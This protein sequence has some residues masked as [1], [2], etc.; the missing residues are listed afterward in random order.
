LT[1]RLAGALI[2]VTVLSASAPSGAAA[3]AAI[4]AERIVVRAKG[5]RAVI[6]REPFRI[7]FLGARGRVLRQVE[8]TRA[9][10]F[11]DTT[12]EPE[13]LGTDNIPENAL[14]EPLGFEV[15]GGPSTQFPGAA[16]VGNLL[17]GARAGVQYSARDVV[18]V[19]RSGGG[20]RLE[21]STSDPSGRRLLVT[22][23]PDRDTPAA[24]A[25]SSRVAPA[26]GV[27]AVADSFVAREGEAFRGFGGR[28]NALDQRGNSFI[29]WI[30][31][32]NLSAG[33]LEFLP[34]TL[35]GTGGAEF[36]QFPN[37]PTAAW[38]EQPLFISSRPYGFLLDRYELARF[39]MA[40]G[41]PD[42]WQ[43]D[44]AGSELDYV[45]A[46]GRASRAIRTLTSITG[47]HSL[48]PRWAMGPAVWRA[49]QILGLGADTPQS[50]EAKVRRDLAYF[51]ENHPPLTAY[52]FEGWEVLPRPFVAQTIK[53]LRRLGIHTILYV[54]AFVA[55]DI[56]GT[57]RPAVFLDAIEHGYVAKTDTGLPFLFGSNFIAGVAALLDF[58][59]SATREYWRGRIE[60]M[61]DLGADGFMQD[62]G[63]QTLNGMR[64][65]NGETGLTM[66]NRY[67][68][69][70]H[71]TT[72][73]I[74]DRY[75]RRHPDREIFF[76][77]RTGHSGRPGSTRFEF[78]NFPGDETTDWGQASGLRALIPDML[79][80][81]VGGAFGYNTDIGGYADFITGQTTKE[82]FL[83]WAELSALTPFYRV[84]NSASSGT[85]MPWSFDLD[86]YRVW[87]RTARLHD[88][89]TPLIRRLWREG[90]QTGMPPVRPLWLE[91]P[92]D[93]RAGEQEQQFMLGPDV[94]VAPVVQQGASSREVYF[95]RGCWE[96]PRG[97]ERVRGPATRTVRA[98]LARLPFFFRCG[99]E[100]F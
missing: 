49:V 38:Y 20:V 63:E 33:P 100:A 42:A 70:Y 30:Q 80:R 88:R 50:Y 85:R 59:N 43:V 95:P 87:R 45:V 13:P 24:I 92:G 15:G 54:R 48:P 31:Q 69:V 62:F 72:R 73:R 27:V 52:A 44:V 66:H 36:Y 2:A 94:M 5:A 56:A 57:E 81:G 67:P 8:N 46:P 98:P 68:A 83:R 89:A 74:V 17:L 16:W 41:R 12:V 4:D 6:G 19:E 21:L 9:G 14:Y 53:Q 91:F 82:L 55:A 51:E 29:S 32:Q 64:F 76:F 84:H 96:A 99:T 47:R 75:M 39:R 18:A 25:V 93:R 61:L 90:E 1:A 34:D 78:S 3:S 22:V 77:V 65:A 79:N 71:R 23:R 58:T 35:P 26:D 86:A 40:S 11:V 10:P 60:E 97:L 7:E 28:H 37:G